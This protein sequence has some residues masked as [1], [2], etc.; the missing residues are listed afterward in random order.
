MN[1][2]IMS[3]QRIINYGSFLQAYALKTMVEKLGNNCEFI[4]IMPEEG[5]AYPYKMTPLILRKAKDII[6][7]L[8]RT[9]EQ[10]WCQKKHDA[11]LYKFYPMLGLK[12]DLNFKLDYDVIIIGSDEVFNCTQQVYWGKSLQLFGDGVTNSP[13]ISYAA[14]F[15]YTTLERIHEFG[16]DS[17]LAER[18]RRF[19][20][21]SVRDKNSSSIVQRLTG[22]SPKVHCDPALVFPFDGLIPDKLIAYKYMVIYGYTDRICEPEIID[23]I[24]EFAKAK[25]LKIISVGMY[26]EWCD[27]NIIPTPFELLSY[28][29]YADFIVS[30][31]FHGT[32][33]SIKFQKQ[34]AT[35]VR[36][37]NVQKLTDL[38]ERFNLQD[39]RFKMGD[40]LEQLLV[41]KYDKKAVADR[42]Q[43]EYLCTNEYLRKNLGT[44]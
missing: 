34:F 20:D 12:A 14:S 5:Q 16:L 21:I 42:I 24:R 7:R 1:V 10:V 4:D 41:S 37:S 22:I 13:I 35:I 9:P 23:K 27:E 43:E 18:L 39:R 31:T 36:D 19:K 33:F 15:G 30:D 6:R 8:V 32:V 38:L 29:K 3:M 25:D 26:Q 2:G 17:S 40:D 28:F 44:M 11:F